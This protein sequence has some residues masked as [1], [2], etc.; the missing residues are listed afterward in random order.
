MNK[1]ILILDN[2]GRQLDPEFNAVTAVEPYAE[3]MIKKRM[4][5]ER[6]INK[7]KENMAEIS[8]ILID[9]PRQLNRIL[10][11]TLRDELS[12]KID[13]Q[14]MEKL[15]TDI[16]RSSNRLAFS[17]IV[18][19]I[20]VGSS[21]LV[22]SDVGGRIFGLPTIGAIGFLVAIL[23]GVRLLISILRSGRL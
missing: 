15:I 11:K 5:P 8:D 23:L 19:A 6:V 21:M 10:R 22:Q 7:T 2:I 13:P 16:D 18:A 14:G 17:M 20:I 1:T 12:V 4:S 3:N 9:T